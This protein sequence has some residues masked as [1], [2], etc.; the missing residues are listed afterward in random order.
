MTIEQ[1]LENMG[2]GLPAPLTPPGNF[3]LVTLH[4]GLAYIAGHGPFIGSR[5][6]SRDASATT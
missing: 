3:E 2:I 4:G 6:S 1:R 5:C